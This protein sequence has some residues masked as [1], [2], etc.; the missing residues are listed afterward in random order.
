M[1]VQIRNDGT[2]EVGGDVF[3]ETLKNYIVQK[4]SEA[5]GLEAPEVTVGCAGAI[6]RQLRAR[7]DRPVIT[8]WRPTLREQFLPRTR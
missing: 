2:E 5:R 1:V 8:T 4:V 6:D 3:D 7:Q